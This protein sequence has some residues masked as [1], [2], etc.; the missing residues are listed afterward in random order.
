[1]KILGTDFVVYQVADLARAA[2]FY[3]EVLNLPQ[4]MYSQAWEWAEFDCG[5]VTLALHGGLQQSETISGGL[6][7]L[8][9]DDVPGACAELKRNG[10]RIVKEA[11]DYSVCWAAEILDLDGNHV[12]LHKRADG[13]FGNTTGRSKE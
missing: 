13:T 9:V 3:R 12:I 7:A 4:E 11:R 8:A 1:M 2:S 6:I 10:V 5:N